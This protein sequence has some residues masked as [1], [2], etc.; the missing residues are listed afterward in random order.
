MKH[1]PKEAEIAIADELDLSL[2]DKS[3]R[4]D[5]RSLIGAILQTEY[6]MPKLTIRVF[7]AHDS[8]SI[9]FKG[10]K[11]YLSITKLYKIFLDPEKRD[12]QYESIID[13]E[14]CPVDDEGDA[15]LRF[16]IRK[17]GFSKLKRRH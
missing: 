6:P 14:N 11:Q 15:I 16:K 10:W 17:S 3:D 4:A 5:I 7:S 13:V 9:T 8:Y 1:V 12:P 2:V